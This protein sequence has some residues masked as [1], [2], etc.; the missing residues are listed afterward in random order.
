M[1]RSDANPYFHISPTKG[2]VTQTL[3]IQ[4]KSVGKSGRVLRYEKKERVCV[5]TEP[6]GVVLY[7][8]V[9]G[10]DSDT[11]RS[12]KSVADD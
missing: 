6:G 7:V 1:S 5:A 11:V 8:P 9:R 4:R 12:S 2:A 3:V 10:K